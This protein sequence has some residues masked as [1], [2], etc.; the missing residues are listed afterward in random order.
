MVMATSAS[1]T[2]ITGN[3]AFF[4]QTLNDELKL[5]LE[6]LAQHPLNPH[7][8]T[9]LQGLL[10]QWPDA[11]DVHIAI[12]KFYFRIGQ[13]AN[14]ERFVWKTITILC[15]HLE[16]NRNYKKFNTCYF[17]WLENDSAPRHL[18]FCLKAL[19]VIRLRRGRILAAKSVLQKLAELDPHDEIGGDNYLQIANS[20]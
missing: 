12:F 5:A 18:L 8:E 16:I 17:N 6:Q 20:F 7:M 14:A 1:V 13:Y 2:S 3:R 11:V 19:G 4:S 15:A 9:S 10:T